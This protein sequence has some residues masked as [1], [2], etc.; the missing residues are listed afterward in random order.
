M[1]C[2]RNSLEVSF[3]IVAT[4]RYLV[5]NS[6]CLT[7]RR[8]CTTLLRVL[9]DKLRDQYELCPAQFKTVSYYENFKPFKILVALPRHDMSCYEL[10][11]LLYDNCCCCFF[12]FVFF[13]FRCCCLFCFFFLFFF[14]SL[15]KII[16]IIMI[17]VMKYIKII[18]KGVNLGKQAYIYDNV[19]PKKNTTKKK[20]PRYPT[21]NF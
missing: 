17:I 9:Y 4:R 2:R 5:G 1:R 16:I 6:P 11:R 18:I 21:S 19:H 3:K 13:F 14:P 7:R 12:L 20:H 10:G 8:E 15:F